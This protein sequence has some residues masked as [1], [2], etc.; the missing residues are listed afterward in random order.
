[1]TKGAH[2][3]SGS[4]AFDS[5][6]RHL[7]VVAGFD[8][9]ENAI[10]ALHYAAR[11]AL[12]RGTVLTVVSSFTVPVPIYPN[13]AS[14]P[15]VPE[16]QVKRQVAEKTLEGA[17]EYLRE[18]P[19]EVVYRAEKGDAAGV[20]VDLSSSAQLMIVGARG[21][22]GF[23]GRVLGSVASALPAHA[24]CPT[25]VVPHR[26][27][28]GE[29]GDADRFAPV[30]TEAPVV[31]G[32]DGSSQSRV[33]ALQAAQAAADHEVPLRMVM[34]LP[35]VEGVMLWYP[36]LSPREQQFVE[37]RKAELEESLGSEVQW[38]KGHYP[39]LEVTSAVETGDP[40]AVLRRAA[41]G[42]QLTV[43]G[44]RG[45]GGLA[46]TL[47]GSVSRGLLLRAQGAVM[48]VPLLEEERLDDEP[49]FPG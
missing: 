2:T 39:E 6:A 7:G 13:L 33:A 45:R 26:D 49:R 4:I 35:P 24:Q 17:R 8:G 47:L 27:E 19:G 22:G 30:P 29:T 38:V 16:D 41:E 44:T 15:D 31:V 9:S 3:S 1:M 36:A 32:L 25:V 43:V 28:T 5:A 40:V 42:A 21:R 11:A 18:Y 46:S 48:V 37:Q 12:E 34:A 10:S 23:L 20:L 14:L